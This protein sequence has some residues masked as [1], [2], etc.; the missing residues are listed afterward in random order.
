ME[1]VTSN[2]GLI[3]ALINITKIEGTSQ[4]IVS[5]Q[6]ISDRKLAENN[7]KESENELLNAQKIAKLGSF[8]LDL[9]TKFGNC[10]KIFSDITELDAS[11]PVDFYND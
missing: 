3:T 5:L 8:N 6:D 2:G 1:M 10:S 11:K 4:A 7:L 9:L